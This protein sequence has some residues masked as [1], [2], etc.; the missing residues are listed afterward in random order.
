MLTSGIQGDI[1]RFVV[2]A[3]PKQQRQLERNLKRFQKKL[4][5]NVGGC[6]NI[7]TCREKRKFF[8]TKKVFE[9]VVDKRKRT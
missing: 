8:K 9:K 6:G 5:T 7:K 2:E 1:L 4:L 3:A